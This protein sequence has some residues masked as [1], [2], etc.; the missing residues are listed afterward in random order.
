MVNMNKKQVVGLVLVLIIIIG[1]IFVYKNA[2]KYDLPT[3]DV[4]G[5]VSGNYSIEN[6]IALNKPMRCTFNKTDGTSELSGIFHTD[7]AHIYGEFR[8]RSTASDSNF[9]SFLIIKNGESYTWTD[10]VPLGYKTKV[11]ESAKTNAGAK[12]QSQLIGT[13]D[14]IQLECK[15]WQEVDT[16]IFEAPSWITFTSL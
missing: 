6:I 11:A 7:G 14:K 13:E 4:D 3:V 10:I 5:N 15:P 2:S 1:A 8:I 9:S 16:S 12:E